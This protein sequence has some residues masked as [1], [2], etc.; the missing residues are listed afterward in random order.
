MREKYLW[1]A[2]A[3]LLALTLGQACYIYEQQVL[4]GENSGPPPLHPDI[5]KSLYSEKSYDAQWEEFEKWRDKVRARIGRGD[6]LLDRD[7]DVYFDDRFFSD[8]YSPFTE[9]ERIRREISGLFGTSEKLLFD[10]YW[11]KWFEQRMRLREFRTEVVRTDKDVT[12]SITVPGL[13]GETA[14]INITEDRIRAS[15]SARSASEEKLVAGMVKKESYKSYVKIMPVPEDAVAGT[16]KV[17]VDG[18]RIR[19]T[20]DRKQAGAKRF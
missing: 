16:A 19:I 18:D 1:A 17:K 9:M 13:S 15:F 4:A 14:D 20:F 7:F 11:D 12:I 6:P 5:Y 3:A 8:R 2:I 10:G